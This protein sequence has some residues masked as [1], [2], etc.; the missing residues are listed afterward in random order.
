[1]FTP[2][3]LL[4]S[5]LVQ[6]TSYCFRRDFQTLFRVKKRKNFYAVLD[7]PRG[8]TP[9]Q[10]KKSY[11]R[12]AKIYHPDRTK[13]KNGAQKFRELQE[14]YGVLGDEASRQAYDKVIMEDMSTIF[15]KSQK[16]D[17]NPGARDRNINVD[18]A[19]KKVFGTVRKEEKLAHIIK[20]KKYGRTQVGEE[21]TE[22]FI[23]SISLEEAA[24]GCKKETDILGVA[25][26][27]S[28]D[29]KT[30][31]NLLRY[32]VMYILISIYGRLQSS[33]RVSCCTMSI[34]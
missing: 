23:V 34:L 28:C 2:H 29:G 32:L 26:C 10:I 3:N 20:N 31:T 13:V 8:A 27:S 7:I 33:V 5:R 18:A 12:L 30:D 17:I 24:K 1:M 11:L 9:R 25:V 6:S 16:V 4:S 15:E 22:G 14:A 21:I 19:F